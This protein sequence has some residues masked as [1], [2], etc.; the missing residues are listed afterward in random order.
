M[1]GQWCSTSWEVVHG[2][3]SLMC[4]SHVCFLL[5]QTDQCVTAESVSVLLALHT[6]CLAQSRKLRSVCYTKKGRNQSQAEVFNSVGRVIS[7]SISRLLT[8]SW[9]IAK[10]AASSW[11]P[12]ETCWPQPSLFS[13]SVGAQRWENSKNSSDGFSHNPLGFQRWILES[14]E[15]LMVVP[16]KEECCHRSP[17]LN[18]YLYSR[19]SQSV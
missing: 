5:F 8:W 11:R 6:Q 2:W 9:V 18:R 17:G 16:L 13:T 10:H 3:L 12:M 4:L 14:H 19:G 15:T 1:G 7:N